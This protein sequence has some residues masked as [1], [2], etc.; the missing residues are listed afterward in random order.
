MEAKKHKT[1]RGCK[2]K[3]KCVKQGVYFNERCHFYTGKTKTLTKQLDELWTEI[4]RS[5]SRNFEDQICCERCGSTE[6][7][8]AHHIIPRTKYGTRWVLGN[9][10]ALC[11]RCHL[12]WA[13][14]DSIEFTE[15]IMKKRDLRELEL[16]RN[17]KPDKGMMLI[18][19]EN[20]IEK[21]K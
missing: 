16:S 6:V 5:R 9:G 7:V 12:Y 20:E 21:Y 14:K 2:L 19:L 11:R 18:Y 17:N 15:W 1:C 13:H 3:N 8:Q 10:V 4:I